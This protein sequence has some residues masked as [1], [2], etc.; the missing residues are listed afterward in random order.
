MMASRMNLEVRLTRDPE[1]I[2]AAQAL[3]Y[4]VFYEEMSAQPTPAMAAAKRDFD[5]FDADCD[6]LLVLDH[7]QPPGR[8]VV[9]TYRLLPQAV[10]ERRGGFYSA[11]EYDLSRVLGRFAPIGGLLE[12]GR[13]C[14][15]AEY[16]TTGTIQLL[17]RA[18]VTY[19]AEMRITHMFGCASLPGTDPSKLALPLS[20]LHHHHLA[21]EDIRVRALPHRYVDMNMMQVDEVSLRRALHQLPPL[22]KGYLRLGCY[23]GDGAVVDHQFGTTDVFIL[24][25]VGRI[26]GRYFSHFERGDAMMA[27]V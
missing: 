17:W 20:Y 21:P 24:L 4:H 16:R 10:A 9:G 19:L 27:L 26:A 5:E 22:V 13:S 8:T 11:S 6:H 23:V 12:L 14:V 15:R 7:T 1:D 18:I 25:P 3:R 2:A